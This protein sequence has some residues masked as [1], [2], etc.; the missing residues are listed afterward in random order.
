MGL[1]N[2]HVIDYQIN[3]LNGAVRWK[4]C[5]GAPMPLE[6]L[7]SCFADSLSLEFRSMFRIEYAGGAE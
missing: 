4:D 1:H 7:A 5:H 3:G 2:Q 6:G